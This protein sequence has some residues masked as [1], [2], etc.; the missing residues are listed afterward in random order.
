MCLELRR[1]L[2][3]GVWQVN[4]EGV[5][6]KR[7]EKSPARTSGAP[8]STLLRPLLRQAGCQHISSDGYHLP[9]R[10]HRFMWHTVPWHSDLVYAHGTQ[11]AAAAFFLAA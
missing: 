8:I 4:V 6:G 7:H 5:H 2:I 10:P 11:A 1:K 3:G 9:S